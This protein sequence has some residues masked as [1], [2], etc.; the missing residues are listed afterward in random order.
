MPPGV[1][2]PPCDPELS[3]S[4]PR[5]L[6]AGS[7]KAGVPLRRLWTVLTFRRHLWTLRRTGVRRKPDTPRLRGGAEVDATTASPTH[8][9]MPAHR[10]GRSLQDTASRRSRWRG[11]QYE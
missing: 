3:S 10:W 2:G 11:R 5:T 1:D 6:R 8:V 7:D 9:G 4:S